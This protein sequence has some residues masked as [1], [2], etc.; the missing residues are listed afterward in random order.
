MNYIKTLSCLTLSFLTALAL[1]AVDMENVYINGFFSQGY[2]KSTDNNYQNADVSN[3]TFEFNVAAIN[4]K[5]ILEDNM[6][7]GIQLMSRDFGE[8]GNN[9][10]NVDWAFL[11][12]HLSDAFGIRL[13]RFKKPDGLYNTIRDADAVRTAILLPQGIYNESIR[14][15]QVAVQGIG[16]YGYLD[17]DK[18]GS[19]D[20]QVFFGN[21]PINKNEPQIQN[22]L[23]KGIYGLSENGKIEFKY[24]TGAQVFWNTPIE[25]F[26]LGQS[27]S[28]AM[29]Q[30]NG[31]N[32][33]YLWYTPNITDAELEVPVRMISSIEYQQEKYTITAEYM[34]FELVGHDAPIGGTV[35]PLGFPSGGDYT[36]KQTAYYL[37]FNYNLTEK[38][39]VGTYHCTTQY[40]TQD[41][42]NK[43]DPFDKTT[44]LA[45]SVKYN[46]NDWWIAKAEVHFIDG[47][48][49]TQPES[50]GSRESDW[51]LFALK[52]SISF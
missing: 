5:A 29:M 16:F 52:S 30:V 18:L 50:N 2:L 19:F 43:K 20:Y 26:K 39:S 3:G 37:Q 36:N 7:V 8:S 14:D 27:I 48:I 28:T 1:P 34:Y 33:T 51:A 45:F 23:L 21:Q 6:T 46:I 4:I 47:L 44:D 22:G 41:I 10:L 13:G 17:A 9:D 15:I 38:L 12:Y 24:S 49:G 25:G 31:E 11:D 42:Y 40:D 35:T 32:D